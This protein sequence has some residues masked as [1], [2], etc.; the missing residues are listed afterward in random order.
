[1]E[2]TRRPIEIE[3]KC[4]ACGQTVKMTEEAGYVVR[5]SRHSLPLHLGAEECPK[6]GQVR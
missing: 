2:A 6:S 4:G 3:D 5:V 1:M